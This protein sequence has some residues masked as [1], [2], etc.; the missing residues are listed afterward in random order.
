MTQNLGTATLELTTDQSKLE[1]GLSD[2]KGKVSAWAS[3]VQSAA[4]VA[5]GVIMANMVTGIAGGM[6]NLAKSGI[7]LNVEL[8]NTRAKLV[9]FTKDGSAADKILADIRTE[10]ANTP[11]AFQEMGA[12]TASLMP[13]AKASGA[14]L[15]DLV[16][17]AEILA[18]S[19]PEQGLQ[20]A[21]IA[22]R[23]AT[24]GDFT[25]IVERFDL[26]RQRLNELKAQGV[27]ALKAVTIAMK[28][29]GYDADL[30]AGLAGTASGRWSTFMD[31]IDTLKAAIAKPI[32]DILSGSLAGMQGVLDANMPRLQ[33]FAET[34][35]KG[36]GNAITL[37]AQAITA[38][39]TGAGFD[40][41][42]TAMVTALGPQTAAMIAAVV[43]PLAHLRTD[44]LPGVV[45]AAQSLISKGSE[46][47]KFF[48]DNQMAADAM[49]A[50][51]GAGL[52]VKIG[53]MTVA[54]AAQIPVLYAQA[55][56]AAASAVATAA[57]AAP[58]ILVAAAIAGAIFVG[59]EIWRNWDTITEKAGEMVAAVGAA[60]TGF[61]EG[62]T[63]AF[64][65]VVEA[66]GRF[67][68]EVYDGVT[69]AI[70]NLASFLSDRIGAIPDI[71]A[72]G[73]SAAAAA[74]QAG[75]SAA[76][77]FIT[78][79]V[80]YWAG[81]VAG[82][83][84]ELPGIAG[85]LFGEAKDAITSA[86]GAAWAWVTTEVPTWPGR[87]GGFLQTVGVLVLGKF[88][89]AKNA[90]TDALG[91]AWTW[92]STNVPTWPGAI[93]GFLVT[94]GL[95]VLGK[96]N[97]AKKAVT[98]TL[99]AAWT[100]VS[101]NVPTW[102]GKIGDFLKTLPGM[103]GTALAGV[104]DALTKPFSDAL[105]KVRDIW[106]QLAGVFNAGKA[107]G[108]SA[109]AAAVGGTKF[110]LQSAASPFDR[111]GASLAAGQARDF[112]K[113][114]Q[115]SS[116]QFNDIFRSEAINSQIAARL[117]AESNYAHA[118]GLGGR[119]DLAGFM[120]GRQQQASV[121]SSLD[122]AGQAAYLR[123]QAPATVNVLLD[124]DGHKLGNAGT[125]P[126]IQTAT[127]LRRNGAI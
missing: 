85:R 70:T 99:E 110:G 108:Q 92:V 69:Q 55:T 9:A 23:E 112:G 74:V 101:E 72:A 47:V 127:Q 42:Y 75:I 81:F 19:H 82:W 56:A 24:S 31:T 34:I 37:T 5:G 54:F 51:V 98:D 116:G 79:T 94:L 35:G 59:I 91:A 21:A 63:G 103:I 30:V 111:A 17:Q 58:F 13:V 86:L 12:A 64:R 83:L 121:F 118:L 39:V 36:I 78:S 84:S 32:F 88:N 28:E 46:L 10:A 11:F 126:L 22:L 105:A 104:Y 90:V 3:T 96:F 38:L 48:H 71:F 49:A 120:A 25:S 14:A 41:F 66:G 73:F 1:R 15:M 102:P 6:A 93:A 124:V 125:R 80:P 8:E 53:A 33:A 97:E 67:A 29:M 122:A 18:A 119:G 106:N 57:A 109:G 65:S 62:V 76:F 20:G 114:S 44:T 113:L 52:V 16:K 117:M 7:G 123:S 107:A 26:P 50:A 115:I 77:T 100:W 68:S 61:S 43:D 89:E 27:P 45:T 2:S 60:I 87:I 4:G 40:K 95:N